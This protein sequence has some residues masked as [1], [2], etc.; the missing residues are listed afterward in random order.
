[1]TKNLKNYE[2]AR[3]SLDKLEAQLKAESKLD[4]RLKR[5]HGRVVRLL[6]LL[7]VAEGKYEVIHGRKVPAKVAKKIAKSKTASKK[8]G[9]KKAAEGAQVT[10][11]RAVA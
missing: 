3:A 11:L 4:P 9:G 8:S 7:K 6:A 2:A 5:G 10:R 1:M